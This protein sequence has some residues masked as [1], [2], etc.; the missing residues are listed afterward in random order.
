MTK[1][2]MLLAAAFAVMAAGDSG[3]TQSPDEYLTQPQFTVASLSGVC[4]FT[5]AATNVV[6][7]SGGF[8]QP[9]V[10]AGTLDF[11]GAGHA[12]LTATENKHGVIGAF[13][14]FGGKYTVGADGRT[15]TIDFN[16]TGGPQIQ[17]EI[18]SGGAELRFM[19]TG[20]VDPVAGIVKEVLIGVC[21]F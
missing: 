20:P 1:K 11:N 9:R 2:L 3:W 16:L 6:P 15:G 5:S 7:T 10:S 14:P 12:T 8:L 4:G 21:K 17:F 13:G 19:N 18:V